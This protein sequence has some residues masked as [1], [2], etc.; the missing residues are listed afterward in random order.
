MNDAEKTAAY[1]QART[2]SF[3]LQSKTLSVSVTDHEATEI[4]LGFQ[5]LGISSRF[6]YGVADIVVIADYQGPAQ[7]IC[8][9]AVNGGLLT[10]EVSW[11]HG[12]LNGISFCQGGFPDINQH[13]GANRC[14]TALWAL[15]GERKGK[16]WV[17]RGEREFFVLT[18]PESEGGRWRL[19]DKVVLPKLAPGEPYRFLASAVLLSRRLLTIEHDADY[20]CELFEYG[21]SADGKIAEPTRKPLTPFRYGVSLAEVEEGEQPVTVTAFHSAEP[22]GIYVGDKRVVAD[23][24]GDSICGLSTGGALVSRRG[25]EA[26][27][28]YPFKG[29]P[30][31]LIYIPPALFPAGMKWVR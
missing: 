11:I 24:H 18:P 12:A 4:P 17:G 21:I 29:V 15:E 26:P 28:N 23:I 27:G 2:Y 1:Q 30:G 31:A 19:T 13:A 6:A 9:V 22:S 16:L 7:C 25:M 8:K 3:S 20:N 14:W 5:P 10:F